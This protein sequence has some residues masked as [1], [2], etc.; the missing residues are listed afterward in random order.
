MGFLADWRL[1]G[2]L[3]GGITRYGVS[4]WN[5]LPRC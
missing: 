4:R 2:G 1:G 3:S 5:D